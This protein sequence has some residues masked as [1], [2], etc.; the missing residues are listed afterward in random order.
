[1]FVGHLSVA[2]IGKRIR[3]SLSLGWY[4]AAATTLDLLWPIFLLLGIERVS[5]VPGAMAFNPLVFDYY[6]WS[7]SLLMAVGWGAVVAGL[8]RWRGVRPSVAVLLALLVVSHW[9]LDF[10]TH[11]PDLPLW[12][13][14]PI[15]LGLGLWDSVPGTLILEGLLW[16]AGVVLYLVPR[17]ARDRQGRFA[18][19]SLALVST[20]LWAS[21][22]WSVPAPNAGVLAWFA[23]VG[24]L[25]IP[26]AAWAD[27][28]YALRAQDASWGQ[29]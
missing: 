12:P 29:R 10:V 18:F 23:M 15:R 4:V 19:W 28:H 21:G 14:S 17:R 26:W 20:A 24:W 25:V 22:P 8:A 1:M 9:V 2:L 16:V 3:P 27:R 13:G 11:A 7:H 6:P 5:I